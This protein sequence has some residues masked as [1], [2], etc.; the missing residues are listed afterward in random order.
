MSKK[1][2]I[3]PNECTECGTCQLICS[4]THTGEFN[5]EKANII[6]NLPEEIRFTDDCIESCTL[7]AEYCVYDAI[8]TKTEGDE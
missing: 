6:I 7:C 5:P 1:I 2:S 3:Q 8:T 4:L